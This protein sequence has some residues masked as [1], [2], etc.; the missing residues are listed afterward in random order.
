M[1]IF[2]FVVY[3]VFYFFVL[4]QE[5]NELSRIG[6]YLIS[7]SY[8][9]FIISFFVVISLLLQPGGFF[10]I[11]ALVV[12]IFAFFKYVKIITLTYKVMIIFVALQ[13]Y[14]MIV[15]PSLT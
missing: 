10:L 14:G 11:L 9:F 4:H 8:G 3:S 6:G 5:H 1:P 12:S 7:T 15:V 13:I 2:F